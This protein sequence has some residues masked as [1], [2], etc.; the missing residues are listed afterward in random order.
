MNLGIDRIDEVLA[1]FGFGKLTGV[2]IPNEKS[3]ILPTKEWKR[4]VYKQN[5]Y[6]GETVNMGV[7]QGYFTV[8]PMVLAQ[9]VAR[10]AMRGGGFRPHLVHALRDPLTGNSRAVR[11]EELPPIADIEPSVYARV[12]KGMS[13]VT[14]SPS[15]TAYAVF[16]DAPY[17]VAGKTGTAQVTALKQD[18][19]YAPKLDT[20]AKQFRDHALFIAF[21][22]VEDPQI[23]VAVVAEHAGWGA[24]SA[25]PVARQMIDQF[26]LGKVLYQPPQ[27]KTAVA[28]QERVPAETDA[29]DNADVSDVPAAQAPTQGTPS[30]PAN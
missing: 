22:P 20:V 1:Q 7:G 6:L 13:M 27:A 21:A 8:T 3:G 30:V 19:T 14:Q 24:T 9:A 5:W 2:D 26:L 17:T 23:V 25:A 10:L 16:K 15:G 29:D 28:P 11:P 18:E 4:R 12:I